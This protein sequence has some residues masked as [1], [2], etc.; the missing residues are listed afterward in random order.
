MYEMYLYMLFLN[1][2]QISH[3]DRAVTVPDPDEAGDDLHDVPLAELLLQHRIT[4]PTLCDLLGGACHWT[5][6]LEEV[7]LEHDH[8]IRTHHRSYF[9]M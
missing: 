1:S 4:P 6:H 7:H 5:E 9:D 2:F 3:L 8:D